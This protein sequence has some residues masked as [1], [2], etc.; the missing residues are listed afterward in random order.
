MILR[1]ECTAL[2]EC[3]K[4]NRSDLCSWGASVASDGAVFTDG[5]RPR[6]LAINSQCTRNI[7][8]GSRTASEL[9]AK[10]E[11]ARMITAENDHVDLIGGGMDV[12][13]VASFHFGL[14]QKTLRCFGRHSQITD[15]F[16]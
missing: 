4:A 11:L 2:L 1:A 8:S 5:I 6:F 10:M 13:A 3:S 9:S 12:M 14:R 7:A 16:H 15:T